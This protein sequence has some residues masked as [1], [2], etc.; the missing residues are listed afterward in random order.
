MLLVIGSSAHHAW[1][2]AFLAAQRSNRRPVEL[3][4]RMLSLPRQALAAFDLTLKPEPRVVGSAEADVL[5]DRLQ[6]AGARTIASP[7]LTTFPRERAVMSLLNEQAFVI[8]WELREVQP[9]P[10]KVADPVIDTIA[11]GSVLDVLALPLQDGT[12]GLQLDLTVSRLQR[13]V[14]TE[15]VELE[16]GM[17]PVQCSFPMV[18]SQRLWTKAALVPGSSVVL[19]AHDPQD[20]QALV[21][22]IDLDLSDL[23]VDELR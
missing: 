23:V 18:E 15:E 7:R 9:G 14:P 12:H 1:V 3:S 4:T 11:E 2:E 6:Q 16:P 21:V 10:T 17:P 22:V 8:G 20:D 5:V 13:P 19:A